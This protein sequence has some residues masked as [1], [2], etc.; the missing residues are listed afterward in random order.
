VSI[1]LTLV[2]FCSGADFGEIVFGYFAPIVSFTDSSLEINLMRRGMGTF[3]DCE[4][5]EGINI[6]DFEQ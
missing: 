5:E 3:L 2:A 1:S 6:D 4:D